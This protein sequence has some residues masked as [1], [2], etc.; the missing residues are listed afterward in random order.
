MI[1][2]I[3]LIAIDF[4]FYSATVFSD[5]NITKGIR[6]ISGTIS[7]MHYKNSDV[8]EPT[9]VFEITPKFLYLI[10]NNFGVGA[11]LGYRHENNPFYD[12]D[13]YNIGPFVRYYF[14][15][16]NVLPYVSL[17]YM[18]SKSKF[19]GEDAPDNDFFFKEVLAAVGVDYFI[20]THVAVEAEL[21][22]T[23]GDRKTKYEANAYSTAQ[24]YT[25]NYYYYNLGVGINVFF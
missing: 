2:I 1:K 14:N 13:G 15:N 12:V 23:S 10:S 25:S 5:E 19:S 16:E 22:Y 17:G 6:S 18:Y 4:I 3:S 7:Y 9:K 24:T 20:A 21:K 11:L 8:S